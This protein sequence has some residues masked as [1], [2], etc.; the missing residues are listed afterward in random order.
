MQQPRNSMSST[1]RVLSNR[2]QK[3]VTRR[4]KFVQASNPVASTSRRLMKDANRFLRNR[5]ARD[6]HGDP[7]EV[8]SPSLLSPSDLADRASRN[9]ATTNHEAVAGPL[10]ALSHRDHHCVGTFS[11]Q[12]S[13]RAAAAEGVRHSNSTGERALCLGAQGKILSRRYETETLHD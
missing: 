6:A 10:L 12:C 13:A 5:F 11:Y 2:N 7:P 1:N 8:P 4:A 3:N 9:V